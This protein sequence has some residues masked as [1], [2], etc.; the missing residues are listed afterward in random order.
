MTTIAPSAP[1]I[2]TLLQHATHGRRRADRAAERDKDS[3]LLGRLTGLFFLLTYATSIP[4]VL[5]LYVP[6]LSDP[7]FVLGGSPDVGLTWGAILEMFL[8]LFNVASAV[9]IYPVLKRR[10]PVLS[11]AFVGARLTESMFIGMGIVAILALGTLRA[12]AGDADPAALTVVG[13]ALVALHDWTF[14]MGPGVVVGFGNGIILGY[15][16]WKTRLMPRFL[17]ILGLVGGPALLAG[18][19]GVMLGYFDFGSTIHSLSVAPEFLWELL[20]GIWLLARGFA[21]AALDQLDAR[22]A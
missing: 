15:M 12:Q 19:A 9:A 17:S 13:Q 14:R 7:T 6:A 5:T 22:K 20:L 3:Q 4:P 8:I 11:L 16:M 10:F 2:D 21:P 18:S 1:A